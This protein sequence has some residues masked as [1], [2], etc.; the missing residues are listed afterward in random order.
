MKTKSLIILCVITLALLLAFAFLVVTPTATPST[1]PTATPTATPSTTPTSKPTATPTPTPTATPTSKP[2]AT[3]EPTVVQVFWAQEG[4]CVSDQLKG[5]IEEILLEY[6]FERPTPNIAQLTTDW[7]R[8]DRISVNPVCGNNGTIVDI[9][10]WLHL[11]YDE[12]GGVVIPNIPLGINGEIYSITENGE[13][14][15]DHLYY[16]YQR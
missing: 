15:I 7:K 16:I 8:G 1:T 4:D 3:P 2:T 6:I 14:V 13:K 11:K 10:I 5:E 9:T 12:V